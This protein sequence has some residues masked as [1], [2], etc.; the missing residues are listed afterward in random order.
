MIIFVTKITTNTVVVIKIENEERVDKVQ[1]QET[2]K[3]ITV[4]TSINKEE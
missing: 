4:M 2:D 1:E 3:V